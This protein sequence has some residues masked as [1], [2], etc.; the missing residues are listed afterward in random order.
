MRDRDEPRALVDRRDQSLLVDADAVVARHDDD[1]RTEPRRELVV[2]VAHRREIQLRHHDR[3][4]PAVVVER[5]EHLRLRD[6]RRSAPSRLR[7]APAPM[8]GAISSPTDTGIYH[9]PSR[10]RSHAAR[11]PLLGVLGQSVRHAARHGAER[12]AH[13]VGRRAEDRELVA[14]A[15]EWVSHGSSSD[16]G[17]TERGEEDTAEG[18]GLAGYSLLTDPAISG[19][20]PHCP[21]FV[22]SIESRHRIQHARRRKDD[23]QHAPFAQG[24]GGEQEEQRDDSEQGYCHAAGDPE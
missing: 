23:H 17:R 1:P 16:T 9:H 22:I 3:V 18:T 14:K 4:A 6:A 13:E 2:H 19:F 21:L 12:V 15:E 20:F 5:R 10:P 8:S 11:R 7:R 24:H